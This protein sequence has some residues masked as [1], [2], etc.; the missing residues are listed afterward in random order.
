MV[1]SVAVAEGGEEEEGEEEEEEEQEREATSAIRSR[2]PQQLTTLTE[3]PSIAALAAADARRAGL[4]PRR[5]KSGSV[6]RR[7][8][9]PLETLT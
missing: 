9:K 2:T 5:T 4:V 8:T 1:D 7:F 6:S 3:R